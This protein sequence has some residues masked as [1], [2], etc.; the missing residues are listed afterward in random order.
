MPSV[1]AESGIKEAKS[2]SLRLGKHLHNHGIRPQERH[3]C[4]AELHEDDRGDL[5]D[6]RCGGFG[7][8]GLAAGRQQQ[9]TLEAEGWELHFARGVNT[10]HRRC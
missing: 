3:T 8:A 2:C 10:A 4:Q 7:G 9:R 5:E 6:V 1:D